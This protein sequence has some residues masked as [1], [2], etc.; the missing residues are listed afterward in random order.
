M[1]TGPFSG[2]HV[3]PAGLG[4]DNEFQL[5]DLVCKVC[6]GQVF[7]PLE[8]ELMRRSPVAL[9]RQFRMTEGRRQGNGT[10]PPTLDTKVVSTVD[11]HSKL[12]CEAEIVAGGGTRL[13]P[14]VLFHLSDRFVHAYSLEDIQALAEKMVLTLSDTVQVIVKERSKADIPLQV[15]T[16]Q[17]EGS[18]YVL[19][20][21]TSQKRPPAI[22][23]WH[24][25]LTIPVNAEPESVFMPRL[26]LRREGQL[27][28]RILPEN[29]LAMLLT[30]ARGAANQLEQQPTIASQRAV[31][32]PVH[33][34]MSTDMSLVYRAMAKTG[35]NHVCWEYG[36][37][38][39]RLSTFD[40]AKQAVKTGDPL[41]NVQRMN[42]PSMEATFTRDP[43]PVHLAM[44]WP[45]RLDDG[46]FNLL[47]GLRLFGT[48]FQAI[49]LAEGAAL[50]LDSAPVIYTVHYQEHRMKRSTLG[51]YLI[52]QVVPKMLDEG[53]TRAGLPPNPRRGGPRDPN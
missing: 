12:V 45:I 8:T 7:A 4:G 16:F 52:T 46:T 43:R 26:F 11:A 41:I 39:A 30:E 38:I 21:T 36:E 50:P 17:W 51:E 33:V 32:Q 25:V 19:S 40:L 24:E 6:N 35:I 13:R 10:K 27:V 23:I 29:D 22:G 2:E 47:F 53:R 1:S 44:L 9:L 14:Q 49:M 15:A 20:K 37:S 34:Q 28:L 3:F 5:H 42:D 48:P 31:Q 18:R